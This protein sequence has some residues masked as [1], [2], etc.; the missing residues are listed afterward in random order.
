MQGM[1]RR[2]VQANGRLYEEEAQQAAKRGAISE[3]LT[4]RGASY[5]R[6]PPMSLGRPATMAVAPITSYRTSCS[7]NDRKSVSVSV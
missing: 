6:Q 4:A 1:V 5:T 2:I 7:F 3:T